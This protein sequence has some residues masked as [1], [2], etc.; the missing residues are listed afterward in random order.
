MLRDAVVWQI[1]SFVQCLVSLPQLIF[2]VGCVRPRISVTTLFTESVFPAWSL[3]VQGQPDL[4]TGRNQCICSTRKMTGTMVM[5]TMTSLSGCECRPLPR[6][7]ISTGASDGSGT[8]RRACQLGTTPSRSPTVSFQIP[9][10]C[11]RVTVRWKWI[12]IVWS[13][14]KEAVQR[15]PVSAELS[16]GFGHVLTD[17]NFCA[18]AAAPSHP[19]VGTL[20]TKALLLSAGVMS[21]WP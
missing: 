15:T 1:Y 7:G 17:R 14:G 20:L 2:C 9:W 12:G 18:G 11:W 21:T 10:G 8:L 4:L 5:W 13:T 6:S 16:E 19:T 3:C